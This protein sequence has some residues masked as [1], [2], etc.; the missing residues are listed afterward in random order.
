[1][2]LSA[3]TVLVS[4]RGQASTVAETERTGLASSRGRSSPV[5]EDRP[6][7]DQRTLEGQASLIAED[8]PRQLQRTVL[9]SIR[10]QLLHAT[11][12]RKQDDRNGGKLTAS[13]SRTKICTANL[14]KMC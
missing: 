4:I 5:A 10:G 3:D 13:I 12:T 7:Q 1:M 11:H 9:A 14:G 2:D 8:R 6:R